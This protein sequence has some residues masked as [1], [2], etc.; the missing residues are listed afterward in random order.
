MKSESKIELELLNIIKNH[1]SEKSITIDNKTPLIG[2]EII[3]S[4]KL[5]ELCLA[6]E[7]KAVKLDFE[8]DWTSATAMSK[9]RG[10]FRTVESLINEFINQSKLKND[11]SYRS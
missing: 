1:V 11:N 2:T 6:L 9:S 5:V 8:F 7:E 4:M 3:D 10:M